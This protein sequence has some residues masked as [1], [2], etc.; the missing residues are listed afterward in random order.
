MKV[1]FN[2]EAFGELAGNDPSEASPFQAV[3]PE[4]PLVS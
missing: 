2:M 4:N 1:E 3:N